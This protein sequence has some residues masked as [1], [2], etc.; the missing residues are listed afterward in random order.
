MTLPQQLRPSPTHCTSLGF[1]F[2]ICFLKKKSTQKGLL[3]SRSIIFLGVHHPPRSA[4]QTPSQ[5]CRLLIYL[6]LLSYHTRDP[7]LPT[8]LPFS[9]EA[10]TAVPDFLI[11]KGDLTVPIP[12]HFAISGSVHIFFFHCTI[13]FQLLCNKPAQNLLA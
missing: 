11:R 4:P 9:L 12:R 2:P 7:N 3:L 5:I 10:W 6:L 8:C 1:G 13:F